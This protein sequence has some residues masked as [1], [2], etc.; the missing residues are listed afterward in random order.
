MWCTRGV[1]PGCVPRGWCTQV[2]GVPG[3]VVSQEEVYPG[4]GGRATKGGAAGRIQDAVQ[5]AGIARKSIIRRY[6]RDAAGDH[7]SS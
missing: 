1:Y 2:G 7:A 4:A 3:E 6:P 5:G